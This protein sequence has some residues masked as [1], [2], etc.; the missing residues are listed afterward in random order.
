MKNQAQFHAPFFAPLAALLL[1]L[2]ILTGTSFAQE[3]EA[4]QPEAQTLRQFRELQEPPGAVYAMTNATSGNEVIVLFRD[5][6]GYL[7]YP[8]HFPT[9]GNGTGGGLG[10]Q[11]GVILS[12]SQ[13]WLLAVNAGSN[14]ISV[15]AIK[16][17]GLRLMGTYPSGGVRPVSLTIHDDELV[18]VVHDTSDNIVGF[19]MDSRGALTM[20]PGSVQPLSSS[21]TS[22]AQISFD[23]HG[24]L[25]LVTEKA[26]NRISVFEVDRDGVASRRKTV[27]SAGQTPFGFA[28]G[29]RDQLFVSEAFGGARE[30]S[31]LTSYEIE[32]DN[33]LRVISRS[34]RS[35]QTAACW[36]VLSPDGRY[37]YV[38]NTGSDTITSYR[39]SCEGHLT[40]LQTIAANTGDGPIDMAISADGRFLY[41]TNRAGGSIGAYRLNPT[42]RLTPIH[43][44][45]D[46]LPTSINGLVAR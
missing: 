39:V 28:L 40:R 6:N 9:G 25:L 8:A 31:A 37:A 15:F 2:T 18:Y 29:F 45:I 43:G 44:G 17:F 41:V 3:V 13:R 46:E 35:R 27:N 42:G 36:V 1:F 19:K 24:D 38:S 7:N 21:G 16:P 23:R 33:A 12:E 10:N 32:D 20:I 34:V 11:G 5:L 14:S 22:P 4:V 26:T 30:A